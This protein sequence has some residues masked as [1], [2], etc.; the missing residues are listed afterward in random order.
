MQKLTLLLLGVII[1]AYPLI[2]FKLYAGDA[3]IHLVYA[4][5]AS[6]NHFF[7]FNVGEKSA[8]VTSPGYM[9][10]LS[11]MFKMFQPV[12]VPLVIKFINILFWYLFIYIFYLLSTLIIGNKKWVYITTAVVSIMPGSVYNST[13]GMENGIFCLFVCLFI[14]MIIKWNWIEKFGA[15]K[16]DMI[17][18]VIIGTATWIRP[19]GIV[20]CLLVLFFKLMSEKKVYKNIVIFCIIYLLFFLSLIYFHYYQTGMI[21]PASGK[22]RMILG[23]LEGITCF[24]IPVNFKFLSRLIY[25][26]PITIFFIV[27]VYF[28]IKKST[29][30]KHCALVLMLLLF[31]VFFVLYSTFL[32]S[33]HLARYIIFIIPYLAIIA[34]YGASLLDV[35]WKNRYKIHIFLFLAVSLMGIFTYESYLRYNLCS[36]DALL[37]VMSA[38]NDRQKISDDLYLKLNKPNIPIVLAY[39][40]V[41]KR[42][43][44]DERFIIRSLDGRVDPN[45]LSYYH[46]GFFDHIS[47]LRNRQ[48]AFLMEY[49]NYN[50]DKSVWSLADLKLIQPGEN[51]SVDGL[52]FNKL[53]SGPTKV[54]NSQAVHKK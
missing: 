12:F 17:L 34:G 33:A 1:V 21:L 11:L 51:V 47:Y 14:Y 23:N 4:E 6:M 37:R 2:Y 49:P 53:P 20:V 39:Q 8:G 43:W 28:I 52:I 50:H 5:N 25:Y 46:D 10:L 19:E 42:Y 40:E 45:L 29:P 32:G 15:S 30:L 38:H 44:L 22:S 16:E 3:V 54:I 13:I 31:S 7:E 24:G 36:R 18:G 27:G 26:F 35:Y 41:Q 9:I 48:V